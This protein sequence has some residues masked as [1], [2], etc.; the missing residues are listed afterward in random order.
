M[1]FNQFVARNTLR[2]KHLYL[3][4]FLS[5]LF[6]VVAYFSFSVF[7]FNPSLNAGLA[8]TSQTV[9]GVMRAAAVIIYIF[10]FF[11]VMY[12]MDIF[13]QTRKREF[14]TFMMQGMS[15][16][17][18]QKMIFQE[19]MIIGFLA[20]ISGI[21]L[22]FAFAQAIILLSKQLLAISL[23]SYFPAR[24]IWMT[25]V[26]FMILFLLISLF[27]QF[28]LPK[29][30]LQDLLKSDKLGKG[31]IKFSTI[32]AI[33]GFLLLALGYVLALV[34][35]SN[36]VP[37]VMLPV[38]LLVI[39]GTSLF[40]N[41]FTLFF[42]QKLKG[43][44]KLFWK[45]TNL[46]LFSDLGFRMKDNA[47]AFFL[48][49]IISTVGFSA[50]AT[51]YNFRYMLM[52]AKERVD[53]EVMREILD[54]YAPILFVGVFIGI[55]FFVAAGSFLYFRLFSDISVDVQKFQ[56][57]KKIGL[58]KSELRKMISQQV[59]ILF[60][61]PI[62]VALLHGLVALTAMNHIFERGLQGVDLGVLGVFF[63]IQV[64]YYLVC[65]FFYIRK[66]EKE[67]A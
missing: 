64:V 49:S 6:A 66:L 8:A 27:I 17:Q 33:A 65:R 26:S 35:P 51:L 28:K 29:L 55:V 25:F 46:L 9:M 40:F 1:N 31:D 50:I 54:F 58:T 60:F 10:S 53:D 38:I 67:I 36:M 11:F 13:L 59:G 37:F 30:S 62:V 15:P 14:G 16:K 44:Q 47:R 24:A 3:A 57:V 12:S 21:L 63:V 52:Q 48:V 42:V 45:K 43:N 41:Q 20:T 32:K 39:V 2:N 23:D 18:L 7:A 19:N 56:M 61:T 4:Y 22:G 5:T 34:A